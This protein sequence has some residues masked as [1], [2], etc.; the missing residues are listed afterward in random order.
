[1]DMSEDHT[2]D[3]PPPQG[4]IFSPAEVELVSVAI[5]AWQTD[6]GEWQKTDCANAA[7]ASVAFLRICMA[8]LS[9]GS[10][11]M[12][13]SALQQARASCE[14]AGLLLETFGGRDADRFREQLIE[15]DRQ[16]R[17]AWDSIEP[18]LE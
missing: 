3:A 1:M 10:T 8:L 9:D 6:F 17:L 5:D 11:Q 4:E 13:F 12:A 16:L 18:K 15:L 2:D 7:K 14:K